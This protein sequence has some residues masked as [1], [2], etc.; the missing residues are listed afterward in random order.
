MPSY[1]KIIVSTV[2]C[3]L[4]GAASYYVY[5]RQIA[6]T[7]GNSDDIAAI[8]LAPATAEDRKRA[9]D[10]KKTIEERDRTIESGNQVN[11]SKKIIKP[12]ITYAGQY[13]AKV[14]VGAYA[15][16]VYEEGGICGAKFTNNGLVLERKVQATK[17]ASSVDCP[18]VSLTNQEFMQK[19]LWNVVVSYES[20]TA[21]GASEPRTFE[22]K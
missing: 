16:G 13:G 5:T 20:S 3:A 7:E 15:P 2:L 10:H 14:E 17:S 8:N 22:V 1:K 21:A 18:V 19:G 11:E 4:F 12:I 6:E 9:E